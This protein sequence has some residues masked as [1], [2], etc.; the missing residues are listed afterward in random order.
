[1]RMGREIAGAKIEGSG[2]LR[3]PVATDCYGPGALTVGVPKD[4]SPQDYL[5]IGEM[6]AKAI[7]SV[8]APTMVSDGVPA[9]VI[10]WSG[11]KHSRADLLAKCDMRQLDK[12]A[13][14]HRAMAFAGFE[15]HFIAQ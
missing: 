13:R 10:Y 15:Q 7:F 14:E 2:F 8:L 12:F 11:K 3:F 6:A 9:T 1:M 5:V 4:S